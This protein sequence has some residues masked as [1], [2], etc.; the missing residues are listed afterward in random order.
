MRRITK[1]LI[2]TAAVIPLALLGTVPAQA[3]SGNAK[4]S[5]GQLL[6]NGETVRT[7][8]TPT[9]QPGQGVDALYVVPD[10]MAITSVVPGKGYH[11]G[12]WAVHVVS[13]NAHASYPLES[14]SDVMDAKSAGDVTVTR[15]PGADFVCPVQVNNGKKK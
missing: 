2:T 1:A 8:V 6:Y 10:Q 9:S 13:W 3:D 7:I 12:R 11:G 14:E 4:V 5:F 15:M